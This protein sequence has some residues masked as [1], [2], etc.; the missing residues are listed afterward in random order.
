MIYVDA[1]KGGG[2]KRIDRQVCFLL[3]SP[4]FLECH[5]VILIVLHSHSYVNVNGYEQAVINPNEKPLRANV[6][7]ATTFCSRGKV[8]CI[9]FIVLGGTVLSLCGGSASMV[10]ACML[11][12]RNCISFEIDG[13]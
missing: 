4:R 11:T 13:T 5:L 6:W 3:I 9:M 7:V 1:L 10:Y 8:L 2:A 12:G